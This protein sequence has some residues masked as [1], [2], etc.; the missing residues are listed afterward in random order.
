MRRDKEGI[1]VEFFGLGRCDLAPK[2]ADDKK[3]HLVEEA[4]REQRD[5][6][7][8]EDHDGRVSL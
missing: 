8:V 4:D 5:D 6:N 1:P 7:L 2:S 3:D